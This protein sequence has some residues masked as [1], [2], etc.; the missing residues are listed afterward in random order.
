MTGPYLNSGPFP[1]Q[2]ELRLCPGFYVILHHEMK[3]E[4]P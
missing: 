1:T 4:S 3:N 2:K